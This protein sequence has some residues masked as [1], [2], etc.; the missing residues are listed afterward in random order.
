MDASSWFFAAVVDLFLSPGPWQS[1]CG[2]ISNYQSKPHSMQQE[3]E[4]EKKASMWPS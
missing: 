4:A 1:V 3:W 2:A